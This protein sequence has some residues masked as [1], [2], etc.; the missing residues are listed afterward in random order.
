MGYQGRLYD[1]GPYQISRITQVL[2]GTCMVAVKRIDNPNKI[3]RAKK[4]K[5]ACLGMSAEA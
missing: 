4:H 2:S 1:N 3:M 5:R